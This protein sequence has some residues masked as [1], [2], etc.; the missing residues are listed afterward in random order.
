MEI[1]EIWVLPINS[2]K[3]RQSDV[4]ALY[5][6]SRQ[7]ADSRWQFVK[8]RYKVIGLHFEKKN[9]Y[10]WKW[11]EPFASIHTKYQHGKLN[12]RLPGI[13]CFF[14]FSVKWKDYLSYLRLHVLNAETYTFMVT[15]LDVY[16]IV[17]K[18]EGFKLFVHKIETELGYCPF[19]QRVKKKA[20]FLNIFVTN[21]QNRMLTE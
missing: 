6:R 14:S 21:F 9:S 20:R 13:K 7:T 18:C 12:I 1:D 3:W 16:E 4:R 15:Y 5:S 8:L 19:V 17:K 10:G 11:H 2:T